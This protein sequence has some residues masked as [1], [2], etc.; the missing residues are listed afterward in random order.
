MRWLRVVGA[1][2][3]WRLREP[4]YRMPNERTLSLRGAD[5]VHLAEH[6]VAAFIAVAGHTGSLGSEQTQDVVR[7]HK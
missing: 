3:L 1:E 5:T 4:D 2:V 6:A 7:L